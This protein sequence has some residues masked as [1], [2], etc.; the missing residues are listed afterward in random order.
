PVREIDVA[1]ETLDELGAHHAWT[2]DRRAAVARWLQVTRAK[3]RVTLTAKMRHLDPEWLRQLTEEIRDT[4]DDVPDTAA[5]RRVAVRRSVRRA[6][7]V[8]T[9]IRRCGRL[10]APER[11]HAL[12]IA[13]KK[14]RYSL[15]LTAGVVALD[16][17]P[18]MELLADGQQHFGQLHDVQVLLLEVRAAAATHRP[19]PMGAALSAMAERLERDCREIHA[20]TLT[21]FEPLSSRVAGLR[22]ELEASLRAPAPALPRAQPLIPRRPIARAALPD[23]ARTRK[24]AG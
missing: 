2:R 24:R 17:R 23:L 11:L 3:R 9:A 14:L 1:L 4:I 15:E 8:L 18:T 21:R 19:T 20:E 5:A 16:L 6:A 13:I 10:Y 22:R 12:R 7:R